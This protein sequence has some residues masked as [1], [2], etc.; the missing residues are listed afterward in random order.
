[1]FSVHL[2]ILEMPAADFQTPRIRQHPD[3]DAGVGKTKFVVANP[4]TIGLASCLTQISFC[5]QI[6]TIIIFQV[7]LGLLVA[8]FCAIFD[9]RRK[10]REQRTKEYPDKSVVVEG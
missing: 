6:P 5:Q 9:Q 3:G 4:T 8:L 10:E 2:C 7:I 1:M